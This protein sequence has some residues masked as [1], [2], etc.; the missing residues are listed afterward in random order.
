VRRLSIASPDSGAES[1]VYG[2][3][4]SAAAKPPRA[5]GERPADG[6]R[7]APLRVR[8]RASSI[9][10]A[11]LASRAARGRASR[12][13]ATRDITV[14]VDWTIPGQVGT[15]A[16]SLVTTYDTSVVDQPGARWYVKD[17]RASTQPMGTP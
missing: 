6:T 7:R 8:W 11:C 4:P 5:G 15:G 2:E 17:I 10:P 1:P 3:E 13:G 12:R 16:P 14:T 9:G